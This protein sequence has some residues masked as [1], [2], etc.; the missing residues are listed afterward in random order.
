MGSSAG[1]ADRSLRSVPA[2]GNEPVTIRKSPQRND[3]PLLQSI[4]ESCNELHDLS[5]GASAKTSSTTQ[6]GPWQWTESCSHV[7]AMPRD[8]ITFRLEL[9]SLPQPS[10]QD[11]YR[12]RLFRHLPAGMIYDQM[13]SIELDGEAIRPTN[14]SMSRVLDLQFNQLPSDSRLTLIYHVRVHFLAEPM[15]VSLGGTRLRWSRTSRIAMPLAIP[16]DVM[17]TADPS[18]EVLTGMHLSSPKGPRRASVSGSRVG[19]RANVMP[20]VNSQ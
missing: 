16:S 4:V 12:T 9:R 10:F 14:H 15:H 20:S 3:E 8:L 6:S 19:V 2:V 1:G 13:G 11:Q 18:H 5:R 17:A 7:I